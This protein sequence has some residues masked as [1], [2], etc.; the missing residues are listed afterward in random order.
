MA[1]HQT[2]GASRL[3]AAVHATVA[4]S[5]LERLHSS[6]DTVK[7]L[8]EPPDVSAPR[9]EDPPAAVAD[10][11][12]VAK[13]YG[14]EYSALRAIQKLSP[15]VLT[16]LS[17]AV[18]YAVLEPVIVLAVAPLVW[19]TSLRKVTS[20]VL[21]FCFSNNVNA[22][23]KWAVQ[24]PRPA[25][26]S[27]PATSGV[28]NVRGAWEKDMSF[29]SGHTQFFTGLATCLALEFDGG[30][31]SIAAALAVGAVAGFTRNFLGVHFVTD[32]TVGWA[33]GAALAALWHEADPFGSSG[34]LTV[35]FPHRAP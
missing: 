21:F 13:L 32:T 4:T 7:E 22:M 6:Y 1:P 27:P 26:R 31:R 8:W 29:P 12:L 19:L 23:L 18:H 35:H 9:V 10:G 25:W 17:L 30:P 34:P 15:R 5:R 11:G 2:A 24:R 28:R 20:V 16:P 33:L 14:F 3:R